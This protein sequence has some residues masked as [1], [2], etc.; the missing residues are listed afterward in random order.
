YPAIQARSKMANRVQFL[1]CGF[2]L[3][4]GSALAAGTNDAVVK[5]SHSKAVEDVAEAKVDPAVY[6]SLVG[7]YDFD[8]PRVLRVTREGSHLF[9]QFA[10]RNC[11][12]FPKS[13][14]EYFWKVMN[15]QVTFVKND[16]GK[17]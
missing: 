2:V 5:D 4:A 16:R 7:R 8:N 12:I 14:T 6:D 9:A 10:G 15:A 3:I 13:E 11:E 1:I 17:V